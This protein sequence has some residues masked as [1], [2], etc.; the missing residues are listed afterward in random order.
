MLWLGARERID[1]TVIAVERGGHAL[2][3]G[4]ATDGRIVRAVDAT[5]V[6][7]PPL[8]G[9]PMSL[10]VKLG[11]RFGATVVGFVNTWLLPVLFCV[12]DLPF[13]IIGLLAL[14]V[15]TRGRMIRSAPVGQGWGE[16]CRGAGDGSDVTIVNNYYGDDGTYQ[17]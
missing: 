1:G 5:G 11:S 2:V 8:V 7:P 15:G 14:L 4:Q 13:A 6:S 17:S 12:V 16:T 9:T 3:E 10:A